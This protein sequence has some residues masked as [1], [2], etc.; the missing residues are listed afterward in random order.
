[1]TNR[2]IDLINQTFHFPAHDFEVKDGEL[3][4]HG[5]RMMDLVEQFG[6]PLRTSYL[7]QIKHQIDKARNIFKAAIEKYEYDGKY[8][9][10]YCTKSSHFSFVMKEVLQAGAQLETS[11]AYDIA[12]INK[13]HQQGHIDPSLT[14]VCNGFKPASYLQNISNL[15]DAGFH[16][17][18]AVLDDVKEIEAYT[19]KGEVPLQLGIRIAAEEE[20]NFE[21]Y[22]SRLGIRYQDIIKLYEQK[23]K[24]NPRFELKMLHFFINTGIKDS[25]YYWSELHKALRM[26]CR[27]RQVCPELSVL[28]IGGGLP[29]PNSLYFDYDYNYMLSEIVLQVKKVCQEEQVP[30]PD[31]Y[32]EFGKYTVGE[33]GSML[34]SVLQQK[35]QNDRERWYMIDGSLMTTLPD[36]WGIGERFILLPLNKWEN[37]YHRVN[38]GGL[39]CD[40]YDYY[41]SEVHVAELYMPK[42][43][44]GE[45]LYLGFFNTGA[46]QESLSGFGGTKHCLLPSPQF[47]LLDRDA[48]GALTTDVFAPRQSVDSM[49]A[50]LGY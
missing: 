6:T 45:P 33:S 34:F 8:V 44:G 32:S 48:K 49:L 7:P 2:Y 23:I 41:N 15:H 10:C 19:H 50:V 39:S 21:F 20:P 3:Y 38:I 29:I 22:T 5:V 25:A 13:M 16:N 31:I 11:S 30:V 1:M 42:L 37:E 28:N 24:G 43:D 27:L 26:Y 9:Y 35:Q 17:L 46:Y 14:I 4:Q 18:I 12:L 47:V 40:Q 36:S